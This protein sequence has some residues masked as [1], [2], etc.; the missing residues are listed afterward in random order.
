MIIRKRGIVSAIMLAS[1]LSANAFAERG[2]DG[3]GLL[4]QDGIGNSQIGL[5]L[6]QGGNFG[7]GSGGGSVANF[8]RSTGA[9]FQDNSIYGGYNANSGNSNSGNVNSGNIQVQRPVLP[10]GSTIIPTNTQN[11]FNDPGTG[12][13]ITGIPL[14]WYYMDAFGMLNCE[15]LSD[16]VVETNSYVT[17]SFQPDCPL[18]FKQTD[19]NLVNARSSISYVAD[20]P[21]GGFYQPLGVIMI[22]ANW[23]NSDQVNLFTVFKNASNFVSNNVKGYDKIFMVGDVLQRNI[24]SQRAIEGSSQGFTATP[25]I[26]STL[27]SDGLTGSMFG[28]GKT[29]GE[30]HPVNRTGVTLLVVAQV[31]GPWAGRKPNFSQSEY[32][33]RTTPGV[34]LSNGADNSLDNAKKISA[35]RN[36]RTVGSDYVGNP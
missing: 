21:Q 1:M 34:T 14:I 29:D 20:L 4:S 6:N 3:G 19:P 22:Q 27:G 32:V 7:N 10:T 2:G 17:I 36:G 26:S 16:P 9:T 15:G 25:S 35:S 12:T 24:S 30:S 31:P 8:G 33:A 18:S 23:D 5:Q 28:Y 11:I 13:N